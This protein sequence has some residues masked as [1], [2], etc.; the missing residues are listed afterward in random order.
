MDPSV[1]YQ[2][3]TPHKL[4]LQDRRDT[5]KVVEQ[6]PTFYTEKYMF[7]LFREKEA[8]LRGW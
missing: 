5:I 2:A 4:L 3:A 1:P 7:S 8:C 6:N